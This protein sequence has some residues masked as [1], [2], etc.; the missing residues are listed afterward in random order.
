MALDAGRMGAAI[1]LTTLLGAG[2]VSQFGTMGRP[3]HAGFSAKAGVTAASLA[4]A[5]TTASRHALDGPVS[6]A[7]LLVPDG[8]A[9]FGTAFA[10]LGALWGVEEFGLGAKLYPSC[11]YTHRAIDGALELRARLGIGCAEDAARATLSLPDFHLAILPFGVPRDPAEALFSA[12]WCAAVALAT[13]GCTSADFTQAGLA[14]DDILALAGRIAAEPRSPLRPEINVDPEDPDRIAVE[15]RDGRRA[16]TGVARWSGAP[17]R[18]LSETQL[19]GKFRDCCRR[20]D[21]DT[22]RAGARS[23]AI[24]AAVAGLDGADSLD[25]LVAATTD[26]PRVPASSPWRTAPAGRASR[27]RHR[28]SAPARSHAEG[29]R[30]SE[31][32]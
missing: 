22:A 4:A 28:H 32:L 21:P 1:S 29:C 24:E 23:E 16:G 27:L 11:G 6:F 10:K 8:A 20:H 30:N 12:P 18:G 7:S 17:G 31:M 19:R 3:L 25:A 15:R 5:G 26:C 9:R 14:R 13:G 2:Y